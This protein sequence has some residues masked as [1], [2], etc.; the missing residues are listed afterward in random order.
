MPRASQ[1]MR[2]RLGGLGWAVAVGVA[3]VR[4]GWAAEAAKPNDKKAAK[5]ADKAKA[6]DPKPM[7]AD[8]ILAKVK[9]PDGFKVTVFAAPPE[10]NYPTAVTAAVT[11]EVYIG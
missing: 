5:A 2:P 11:G 3:H 9:A 8:E 10:V 6:G 7:T 4:V 1:R